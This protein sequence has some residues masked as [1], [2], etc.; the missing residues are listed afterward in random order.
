MSVNWLVLGANGQVGR[1]LARALQ[2]LGP[3]Q[4]LGR[5]D[6]DLAEPGRVAEVVRD[7][8]P[9]VVVNAA[10]Y[11]AVDRAED[12]PELARRLN[13]EAVAELADACRAV[14]AILVHYSTDYVFPG[15]GQQPF[16]PEDEAAPSS[17]YGQTK[18]EGEQ[19][20]RAAGVR[21]LILRTSWVYDA[22]GHNFV[23][24]MLR[25]AQERRE[26]SVV[27]DQIGAPTWAATIA[28]VTAMAVHL[29]ARDGFETRYDGT[30][31][32]CSGGETSWH[33]FAQAIF[34]HA[35]ATGRLSETQR[36]EVAPIASADFPQK[37][38]RPANSRLD[39]TSLEAAFSVTLPHW[40]D[41]LATCL[42]R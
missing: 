4:A 29:W 41:A 40:R 1:Q 35:V 34:E 33:G 12:E 42:G 5:A 20:I 24:T 8:A 25:L 15:H 2:P 16:L 26:L 39:T 10:A 9:A 27:D 36:P 18:W 38:R 6:C 3:G 7:R 19:A 30:Y 23:N 13:A 28:D 21:H 17:V 31:H 14:G 11:T 37:A 22:R 32:L